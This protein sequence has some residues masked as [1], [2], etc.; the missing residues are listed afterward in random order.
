MVDVVKFDDN[1]NLKAWSKGKV[2]Q[3][4]SAYGCDYKNLGDDKGLGVK[5]FQIGFYKDISVRAK[6]IRADEPTIAPYESK[7]HADAWRDNIKK[8]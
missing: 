1:F 8:G 5:T 7:T 6:L 3:I 2:E 4:I